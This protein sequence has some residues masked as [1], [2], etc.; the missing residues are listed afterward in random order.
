VDSDRNLTVVEEVEL[1]ALL[2]LHGMAMASWFVP[3][4]RVLDGAGMAAIK[5]MAF[6]ASAVAAISSPL[7][8][9]AMADRSVAP[10]K[11]LRWISFAT[12][13]LV[14]LLAWAIQGKSNSW[15]ILLLIQLQALFCSPTSSLA[16]SIVF[17]QLIRSKRQFGAIRALGTVGWMVG[18]WSISMLALD[19]SPRAF[20]VS[21]MLWTILGLFTWR[22]PSEMLNRSS[23]Q[24]LTL[25]E[26]FGWDALS[27]LRDNDHRVVFITAALLA[28]PLAAF[29][30]FT[31]LHLAELGIERTSAWMSLGQ[32]SEVIALVSMAAILRRWRFKWVVA[33]G[34]GFGVLRYALYAT[35]STILVLLGLSLHGIAF[36]FTHIG[37][38]IYL[39]K[40]I[41]PGWRTR[42]QALLSLM[43]GGLGSFTGYLWC[44]AWLAMCTAEGR[45]HWSLYWGGLNLLVVGVLIYFTTRYLGD[46]RAMS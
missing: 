21:S 33:T 15:T 3:L 26:R 45:V 4:G 11:V 18:C 23:A 20:Y 32:V 22:L 12:A 27:L 29:Y 34:I 16:G 5:P 25:R 6:A 36:T 46:R 17:S 13:A 43:T 19:A 40:R 24:P 8:F 14:G 10:P 31:P 30:P 7:F 42:A 38:Q 2:F 35:N 44:G 28:I 9:G 37:S 39:A 1:M 41:E